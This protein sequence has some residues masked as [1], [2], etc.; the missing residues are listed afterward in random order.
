MSG[1]TVSPGL[2]GVGRRLAGQPLQQQAGIARSG[3]VTAVPGQRERQFGGGGGVRIPQPVKDLRAG[4]VHGR[5]C[6]NGPVIR[7]PQRV[8][9]LCQRLAQPASTDLEPSQV[10]GNVG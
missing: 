2:L 8:V 6:R 7:R 5:E 9:A 3:G 10:P 4:Q 1:A